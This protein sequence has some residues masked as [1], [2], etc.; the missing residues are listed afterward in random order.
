MTANITT[1]GVLH[2]PT[3]KT[4]PAPSDVRLARLEALYYELNQRVDER[5]QTSSEPEDGPAPLYNNVEDW[6]RGY[7]LVNITRPFGEVGTQRWYWCKQWWRHNEAVTALTAL[8][9]AWEHARLETTGMLGWLHE[10]HYHLGV[11]CS[12]DGPFRE[13]AAPDGDR[14]AKHRGDQ[15]VDVA[16]APANWWNWWAED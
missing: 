13:C 2:G 14:P 4:E 5:A 10:L 11:I 6:V 16:P 9:Y 7:L 8:W 12:P 15:F 1:D 3:V